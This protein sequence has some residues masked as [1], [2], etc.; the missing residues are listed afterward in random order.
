M[1]YLLVMSFSGS[2]M[3]G[4]YLLI[5]HLLKDKVSS[6]LYYLIIKESIL[7]FLIPLP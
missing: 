1:E 7:F 3:M 4:I 2:T 6:R 5:K